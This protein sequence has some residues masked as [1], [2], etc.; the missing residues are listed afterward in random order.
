MLLE[1]LQETEALILL[2]RARQKAD[3]PLAARIDRLLAER[4]QAE[5]VGK[6]LSQAMISM[7]LSGLASRLYALAAELANE[8]PSDDWDQPPPVSRP[9]P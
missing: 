5:Q 3:P 9:L 4:R 7:D 8:P 6:T 1:G 2:I